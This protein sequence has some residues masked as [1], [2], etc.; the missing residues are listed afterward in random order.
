MLVKR[1]KLPVSLKLWSCVKGSLR[2]DELKNFNV[3]LSS[4]KLLAV[5]LRKMTNA[6]TNNSFLRRSTT[7]DCLHK[8]KFLLLYCK[9]R[10]VNPLDELQKPEVVHICVK[11]SQNETADSLY[12]FELYYYVMYYAITHS[13]KEKVQPAQQMNRNKDVDFQRKKSW[14]ASCKAGCERRYCPAR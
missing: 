13:A 11:G 9:K 10:A 7:L 4:A 2:L 6:P 3:F 5:T 8:V 1:P 12:N 14:S